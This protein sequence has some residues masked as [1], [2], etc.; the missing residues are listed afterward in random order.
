ML[1]PALSREAAQYRSPG[2]QPWE[3]KALTP[4][5]PSP[6][7]RERGTGGEGGS[8]SPGLAPWAELWRSLPAGRQASELIK[9][10][11]KPAC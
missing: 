8:R 5:T 11:A 4:C 7:P 3:P 1:T 6:A 2:R 9:A 10:N